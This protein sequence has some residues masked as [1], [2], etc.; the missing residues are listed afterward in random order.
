MIGDQ[1]TLQRI[2]AQTSYIKS[3]KKSFS[4]NLKRDLAEAA[5]DIELME[6]QAK[7]VTTLPR[8]FIRE[9]TRFKNAID[10]EEMLVEKSY[11][12]K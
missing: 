8:P 11:H 6:T 3:N 7:S 10:T 2:E 5:N 1:V 12:I 9:R 4:S